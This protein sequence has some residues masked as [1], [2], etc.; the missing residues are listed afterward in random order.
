M[1]QELRAML[2]KAAA[3]ASDAEPEPSISTEPSASSPPRVL[4]TYDQH[5][6]DHTRFMMEE[7]GDLTMGEDRATPLITEVFFLCPFPHWPS[8]LLLIL[9]GLSSTSHSI[10]FQALQKICLVDH[11][12]WM[13]ELLHADAIQQLEVA[14]LG[15]PSCSDPWSACCWNETTSM[16]FTG[17]CILPPKTYTSTLM[18]P[19]PP[20]IPILGIT[21]SLPVTSVSSEGKSM[22]S[23][24]NEV[25]AS[26]SME[27]SKCHTVPTSIQP[28]DNVIA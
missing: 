1:R 6:A 19:P 12:K 28:S 2:T 9:Y 22:S 23:E 3:V 14:L 24:G 11:I 21:G 20:T 8:I 18:A 7:G 25:M 17:K 13:A 26:D 15:L 16:N 4:W 10:F 5:S 27:I